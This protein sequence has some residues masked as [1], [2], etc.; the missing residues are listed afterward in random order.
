MYEDPFQVQRT[1]DSGAR[2]Y[3]PKSAEPE[4]ILTAIDTLLKGG[5]YINSRY[6]LGAPKNSWSTLTR[7]ENEIVAF[8]KQ[9]MS[10]KQIAKRLGINIRTVE[11]HLSHIY[12]KT[13]ITSR[14]ELLDF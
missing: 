7:R 2:A 1:I 11:N 5:V 9:N 10:N 14:E 3:V 13:G 8:I 4:E 12:F 6:C